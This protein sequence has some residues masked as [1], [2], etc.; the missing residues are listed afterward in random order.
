VRG[1]A[2]AS[3]DEGIPYIMGPMAHKP[4]PQPNAPQGPADNQGEWSVSE[5]SQRLKRTVETAFDHVRVRG[6]IGRVTFHGNGHV[7]FDLK[8]DRAVLNSVVW[9]GSVKN[10][11]IRPEQGLEVIATGRL[12]TFAGRSQY[13]MIVEQVE[14][15]GLGALMALLE[16]RKKKLAAEGLFASERKRA[17]PYLPEV[18][19][20]I[21]SPTGAVIRDIM[22]RL[23]DRFP[24]RVLLWPV[25]VQ[26]EQAAGQVSAAIRGFN[27]LPVDGPVPRPDVLIVARGG[28]SIEDLWAFNEEI[29]VR[30]AAESAIPLISAVGHETDTTLIDFAADRRA[31]TPTAAAEM[32]VPVRA[33]LVADVK[34]F[35]SRLVRGLERAFEDRRQHLASLVRVLPRPDDLTSEAQQRLDML[36][37][38]LSAGL[39]HGAGV[40]SDR[41]TGVAARLRPSL[42]SRSA[43]YQAEAVTRL[44]QRLRDALSRGVEQRESALQGHGKLLRTLSHQATLARGFALVRDGAGALVRSAA[45]L[46]PGQAVELEFH[47]GRREA[48]IEPGGAPRDSDARKTKAPAAA[49]AKAPAKKAAP[50]SKAKTG[51]QGSLF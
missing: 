23:Q 34:A 43:Q 48:V 11:K 39:R 14:H 16:E 3:L 24:R 17:L 37:Q 21:T 28:G 29:V 35:E 36:S 45:A 5:I 12:T 50:Q 49:K 9:R 26:G 13:Q 19:G 18:V 31:P 15:A 25:V 41:L 51:G 2:R 7:Y 1:N 42:V 8:D 10:L 6:E 47:D 33:E 27:A 40:H 22:H 20:V 30:A 32:A 44:A 4:S 46:T 38:R